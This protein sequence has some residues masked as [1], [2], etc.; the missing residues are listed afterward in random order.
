M[1]FSSVDAYWTA[2][3]PIPASQDVR[4]R[5]PGQRKRPHTTSTQPLSLRAGYL[6]CGAYVHGGE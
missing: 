6:P 2:Q 5:R 4:V 3:A 1:G